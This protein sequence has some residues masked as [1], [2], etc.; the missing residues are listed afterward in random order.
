VSDGTGAQE[1]MADAGRG[2]APMP[3]QPVWVCELLTPTG[4]GKRRGRGGL[5]ARQGQ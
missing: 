1:V 4:S 5:C 3:V 2:M